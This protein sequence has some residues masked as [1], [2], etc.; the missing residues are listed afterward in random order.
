[1]SSSG[2]INDGLS[3]KIINSYQ[4]SHPLNH[5]VQLIKDFNSTTSPTVHSRFQSASHNKLHPSQLHV[6]MWL[7]KKNMTPIQQSSKKMPNHR[8]K[9]ITDALY[10]YIQNKPP[11]PS[12]TTTRPN[13]PMKRFKKKGP[14]TPQKPQ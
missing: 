3:F 12:E 6:T 5:R 13:R 11:T 2:E 4:R 8:Y 1:M 9:P 14:K 7:P 10:Q